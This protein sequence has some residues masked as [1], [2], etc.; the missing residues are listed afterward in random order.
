MSRVAIRSRSTSATCARRSKRIPP[1][2]ASSRPFAASATATS[3]PR[4]TE[5]NVQDVAVLDDVGLPLESLNAAAHCLRPRAGRD[6][7][8]PGDDLAADEP[9]CDVGV[10]LLGGVECRLATLQR[11]RTRLG[12]AGGEVRDQIELFEQL[13]EDA[14]ERRRAVAELR[15]LLGREPGQLEL[16]LGVDPVRAVLDDDQWLRRQRVERLGHAARKLA[17]RTVLRQ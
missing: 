16:E 2:R 4:R 1:R 17:Q 10:D 9:A 3:G 12:I 7:V 8:V 11:P 14:L 6:E 13:S 5:T 15:R